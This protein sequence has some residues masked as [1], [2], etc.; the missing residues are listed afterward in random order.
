[1]TTSGPSEIASYAEAELLAPVECYARDERWGFSSAERADFHT[2]ALDSGF[3][4]QLGVR[5]GWPFHASAEVLYVNNAWLAELGFEG[6]PQTWEEFAEMACAASEQP[7][8]DSRGEGPVAGY[9]FPAASRQFTTFLLSG[10]G[11]MVNDDHSAYAFDGQEGL[12][13]LVLLKDLADQGCAVQARVRGDERS[14]F[15]TGRVLFTIAPID[16]VPSYKHAV[17][18]GAGFEWDIASPPHPEAQPGTVVQAY[19]RSFTIF[20]GTP[21]K[22][23]AAW[24]FI[25]WMNRPEQQARWAR[26]TSY[27]PTGQS[28]GDLMAEFWAENPWHEAGLGLVGERYATDPA[29]PQYG[30]CQEAV[31]MMLSAVIAG[32]DAQTAL[33]AAA[34][35]CADLLQ[36]DQ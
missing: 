14:D 13:T 30:L 22:Q 36:S 32:G 18:E 21:E 28:A 5:Y 6:P 34:D 4:P 19:G 9:E 7:F 11:S 25:R 27:L 33:N 31:E 26:G 35:R 12:D 16:E 3:I 15:G 10:G 2:F 24:I 1:M 29:I 17:E 8:S 23:L 20:R